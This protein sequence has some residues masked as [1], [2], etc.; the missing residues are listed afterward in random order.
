[1]ILNGKKIGYLMLGGE[2][3]TSTKIFPA[4]YNFP[5]MDPLTRYVQSYDIVDIDKTGIQFGIGVTGQICLGVGKTPVY[6]QV[7]SNG[8]KYVMLRTRGCKTENPDGITVVGIAAWCKLS[9]LGEMIPATGGVN[10]P[11][12]ILFIFNMKEAAPHVS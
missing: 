12:Y 3:F 10:S 2:S 7:I 9:D 11:S 1:M 4:Y 6:C 5:Q 8:E